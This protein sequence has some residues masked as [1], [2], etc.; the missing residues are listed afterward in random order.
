L[1]EDKQMTRNTLSWLLDIFKEKEIENVAYEDNDT[2]FVFYFTDGS[3]VVVRVN[4]NGKLYVLD[5]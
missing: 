5:F 1:E 2:R 4:W 3:I